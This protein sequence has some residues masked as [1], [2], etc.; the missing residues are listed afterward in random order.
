MRMVLL[1]PP[2]AGKGTLA[3]LIKEKFGLMHISTGDLLREEMKSGSDLGSEVKGYVESGGLVPDDVVTRLIENKLKNAKDA[4]KGYMLDGFPR[5]TPQAN[6]LDRILTAINQ[7]LDC[8]LYMEASLPVVLQR[9]T[10]RRVC[11]ACGALFHL[12]NMPPKEEGKCDACGGE[13]Y[14]RADDNEETIKNRMSVYEEKTAVIIDF[15]EG[16]GKLKKVNAD[17]GTEELL[18][19]FTEIFNEHQAADPG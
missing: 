17:L 11:K 6:E 3:G 15:Y 16:Q 19:T 10:G 9:L 4:D 1:G 14:Q 12:T 8:A 18:R 2:G 13:L 5:T 7:P